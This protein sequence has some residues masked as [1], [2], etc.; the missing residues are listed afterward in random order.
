MA[1]SIRRILVGVTYEP[2]EEDDSSAFAYGLSL[3]KAV[4]AQLTVQ[5]S[6]LMLTAPSS[7][8]SRFAPSSI[9]AGNHRRSRAGLRARS[10]WRTRLPPPA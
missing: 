4:D 5:A 8:I 7:M 2:A 1:A 3:A 6:S 10:S 9:E